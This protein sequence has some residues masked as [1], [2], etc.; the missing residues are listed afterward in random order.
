[1]LPTLSR[2]ERERF[3]AGV[4]VGVLG[5][6]DDRATGAAPLLVPVWYVYEPGGEVIWQTARDSVKARLVRGAGRVSLCVQ[7]ERAPYRYVSVEG[8]VVG[9]RDP[10]DAAAR[11]A[12]ARRYLPAQDAAAYLEATRAQLTDDVTFRMRPERWRTADFSSFA[13]TFG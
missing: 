13:A 7:D 5:V 1:M 4:H 11:A 6:T 12:A 8:P 3:L 9:E 10:A 2:T